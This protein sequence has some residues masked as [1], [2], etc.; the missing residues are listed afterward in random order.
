MRKVVTA[1]VLNSEMESVK[2][3]LTLPDKYPICEVAYAEIPKTSYY[4]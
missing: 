3:E 1:Q 4:N 2:F